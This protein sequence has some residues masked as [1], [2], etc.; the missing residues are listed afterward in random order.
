MVAIVDTEPAL[1]N[2]RRTRP[3]MTLEAQ[4]FQA[5]WRWWI[6]Y[7]YPP[8]TIDIASILRIT[9][10]EVRVALSDLQEETDRRM[11]QVWFE[12]NRIWCR[13]FNYRFHQASR[14][15]CKATDE[16]LL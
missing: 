11:P 10:P 7:G 3:A 13:V 15:R 5:V 1:K 4:V 16:G 9:S 2:E 6:D 8:T 14:I 12:H